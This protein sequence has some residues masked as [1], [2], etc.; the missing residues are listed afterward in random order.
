MKV[1]LH[2]LGALHLWC[3]CFFCPATQII[4][5]CTILNQISGT[6]AKLGVRTAYHHF[7]LLLHVDTT[8]LHSLLQ[9]DVVGHIGAGWRSWLLHCYKGQFYI[10]KP[11]ANEHSVEFI[12]VSD[13]QYLK[14][15]K[16]YLFTFLKSMFMN[17]IENIIVVS[18]A[19]AIVYWF[20][21]KRVYYPPWKRGD[22]GLSLS[23]CLS[24]R[25]SFRPSVCPAW[26]RVLC[27][28]E[29]GMKELS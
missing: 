16:G 14:P 13:G 11:W 5:I 3:L 22:K 24:V 18:D 25:L 29:F 9:P 15:T 28:R 26:Y 20:A 19:R 2:R 17:S 7:T 12:L 10:R 27:A 21:P 4:N 1:V 23:V 8:Q 6:A